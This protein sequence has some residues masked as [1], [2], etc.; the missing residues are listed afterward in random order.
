MTCAISTKSCS[1]LHLE[2]TLET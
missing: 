1:G 2:V